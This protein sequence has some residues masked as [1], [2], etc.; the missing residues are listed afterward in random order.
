MAALRR[1]VVLV[2]DDNEDNLTLIGKIVESAGYEAVLATSGSQALEFVAD[3]RPDLILLDIMMPDMDGY[4]V[5]HALK[6]DAAVREVPVLFLT[7]KADPDD[8]TRGFAAGAVDFIAK[9]FHAAELRARV[10]THL[11]LKQQRDELFRRTAELERALSH[12]K[13]LRGLLP[14]CAWCKKI[15][16]DQGYWDQL[17]S[18]LSSHTDATFS[19]A[20]CPDCAARAFP[21]HD[22]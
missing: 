12:V 6:L 4:S 10:R 20:I 8:I 15:R 3:D 14:I 22:E 7:A 13:T 18:Y 2:V 9:P 19:H 17:E 11:E 21:S 5:C 16:N 1:P